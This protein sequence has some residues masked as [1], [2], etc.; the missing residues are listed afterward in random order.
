MR[1]EKC[2]SVVILVQRPVAEGDIG[3]LAANQ[4]E[5]HANALHVV[6]QGSVRKRSPDRYNAPLLKTT[7]VTSRPTRSKATPTLCTLLDRK[8]ARRSHTGTTPR[9]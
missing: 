7:S 1:T 8:C 4:V 9:C 5:G 6:G 3:H 2:A